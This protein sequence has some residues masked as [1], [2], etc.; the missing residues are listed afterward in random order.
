MKLATLL[1][2][3]VISCGEPVIGAVDAGTA[4]DAAASDVGPRGDA[5][6]LFEDAGLPNLEPGLP[7]MDSVRGELF[8][9]GG[10]GDDASTATNTC[11]DG[12]DNDGSGAVDCADTG[13]VN[14][15]SCCVGTT[16]CCVL[17]DTPVA[18]GPGAFDGCAAPVTSCAP[19]GAWTEFGSPA[20][21]FHGG[22]ALGGDAEFDSGLVGREVDLRR[23]QLHFDVSF[24]RPECT[25]CLESA[26]VGLATTRPSGATAHVD[27]LVG[28]E[29]SPREVLLLVHG[30]VARRFPLADLTNP[31]G[32][33]SLTVAPTGTATVTLGTEVSEEVPFIP[34]AS[35]HLAVWGR[36]ENPDGSGPV[37]ARLSE[38]QITAS[39]C[40]MPRA[41]RDRTLVEFRLPSNPTAVELEGGQ[42]PSLALD[43]SGTLQLALQTSTGIRLAQRGG[44]ESGFVLRGEDAVDTSDVGG[45]L[46]EPSLVLSDGT[47]MLYARSPAGIHRWTFDGAR[48][49]A[50]MG[51]SLADGASLRE[52]SVVSIAAES[53]AYRFA[54]VAMD[55]ADLVAY[56]SENGL[57]WTR[58]STVPTGLL[59][60]DGVS[61]PSL[62][63][64]QAAYQLAVTVRHGTREQIALF[65]SAEFL[66]WRLV[67]DEILAP[68]GRGSEQLGVRH[69]A[70]MASDAQVE[71]V[72]FGSDGRD[73]RL[74]RAVRVLAP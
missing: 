37:G 16:N 27:A 42:Q 50:P 31:A 11:Y 24:G 58:W 32:P 19:L 9:S 45:P 71:M 74:H 62:Q 72:Y 57:L 26:A 55:G 10:E 34:P 36:S 53:H 48:F 20:P 39:G 5:P 6:G 25:D 22:L 65:S 33:W 49:I 21:F 60:G 12:D 1:V 43:A 30:R 70:A 40:D 35:A 38:L 69:A 8:A 14:L 61:A 64:V 73:D 44:T 18:F 67:D 28:L 15:V 56:A 51:I 46:V 7:P 47:L 41:W 52:V 59:R 2:L 66:H 23:E 29:L 17:Q 68:E 4:P 3:S 63:V 54:M 13:C